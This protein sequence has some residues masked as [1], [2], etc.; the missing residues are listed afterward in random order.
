M[1]IALSWAFAIS[2]EIYCSLFCVW[3]TGGPSVRH[4][5][6]GCGTGQPCNSRKNAV[7]IQRTRR[8]TPPCCLGTYDLCGAAVRL[9]VTDVRYPK[10][11][12]RSDGQA[13][14]NSSWNI[15]A[16]FRVD[17]S[18]SQED[19]AGMLAQYEA[20]HATGMDV[21]TVAEELVAWTGGYPFL[22]SRLCQLVD[23]RGF[24]WD[25]T[26][27]DA[28]VRELLM[29]RSTLFNS[30]AGKLESYPALK[31]Q[32]RSILMRARRST[33]PRSTRPRRSLPC[34]ASS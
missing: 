24:P 28:A 1:Y 7:S 8:C 16:E 23:E 31:E 10:A 26:G 20:D 18:F 11:K 22:V 9:G 15:A 34:T 4:G 17:M 27:V 12:V 14:V 2:F 25:R 19:V 3:G 5:P 33:S 29:E 6:W 30:L 32:L 21:A 13:K